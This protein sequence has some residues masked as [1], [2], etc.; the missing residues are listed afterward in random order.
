MP[1]NT[2]Y[3]LESANLYCGDEQPN[4]SNHLVIQNLKLPGLEENFAEHAAGGAP[5]AI[6]LATHILRLEATFQLVGYQPEVMKMIGYSEQSGRG[7]P[8][9]TAY[10]LLRD[11]MNAKAIQLK[12]IMTGRLGRVN[13]TEFRRGD[14]NAIEYSIKGITQYQLY[15]G[16][17]DAG[18]PME[19]IYYWDFFTSVRRVG[20]VDLNADLNRYLAIP[21]A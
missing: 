18:A 20:G 19:E 12:G 9:F 10:G 1:A 5:V 8:K 21:G 4:R 17:N 15:M 7:N 6:E 2:V 3:V 13:P 14:P 16:T 11:R